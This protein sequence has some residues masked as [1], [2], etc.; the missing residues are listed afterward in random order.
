MVF[1]VFP[2][3]RSMS[4]I[5][6]DS[7]VICVRTCSQTQEHKGSTKRSKTS[8]LIEGVLYVFCSQPKLQEDMCFSARR[9]MVFP[10]M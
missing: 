5:D 9:A 8:D 2:E 6:S 7:L 3:R 10:R 1:L 4:Q